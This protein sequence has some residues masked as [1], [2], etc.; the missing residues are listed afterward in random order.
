MTAKTNGIDLFDLFDLF[1]CGLRLSVP[2][3]RPESND[4]FS[5]GTILQELFTL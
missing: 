5:D 4:S 3:L 1:M 2:R